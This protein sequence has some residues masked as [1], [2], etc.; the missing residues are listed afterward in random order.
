M[1]VGPRRNGVYGGWTHARNPIAG[2]CSHRTCPAS[3]PFLVDSKSEG[4]PASDT[5]EETPEPASR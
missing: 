2:R 4:E 3:V 1:A 5:E